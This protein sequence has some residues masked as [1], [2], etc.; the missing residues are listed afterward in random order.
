MEA[1]N[2]VVKA[3]FGKS[4]DDLVDELLEKARLGISCG[5]FHRPT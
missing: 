2:A 3:A 5:G 1:V 4:L